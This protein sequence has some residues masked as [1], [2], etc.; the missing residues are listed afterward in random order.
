MYAEVTKH[1]TKA[2]ASLTYRKISNI[3]LTWVV[4]IILDHSD[5]GNEIVDISDVVGSSPVGV[6]PTTSSFST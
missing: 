5:V 4:D 3:R 2:R 1:P 6:A